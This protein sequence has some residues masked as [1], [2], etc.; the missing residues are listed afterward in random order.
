VLALQVRGRKALV[1]DP[2]LAGPLALLLQTSVLKARPSRA[3]QAT[4]QLRNLRRRLSV[5]NNAPI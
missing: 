2:A 5:V 1:I 3:A 4:P